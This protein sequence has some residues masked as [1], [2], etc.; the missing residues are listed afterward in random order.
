MFRI[1]A[2]IA[3]G[4][5]SWCVRREWVAAWLS[6][7]LWCWWRTKGPQG[8]NPPLLKKASPLLRT[9]F[10]NFL[11]ELPVDFLKQDQFRA[12]RIPRGLEN[13]S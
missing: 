6:R 3:L 9:V 10:R 7:T 8:L 12:T 2:G 5:R 4:S 11:E 13:V 1:W